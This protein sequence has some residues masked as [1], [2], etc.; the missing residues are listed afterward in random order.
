MS[1]NFNSIFS[2]ISDNPKSSDDVIHSKMTGRADSLKISTSYQDFKEDTTEKEI[3]LRKDEREKRFKDRR[4]QQQIK[5]EV[6]QSLK[7]KMTVAKDIYEEIN[8]LKVTVEDMKNFIF[9]FKSD[10]L[11]SKYIGIVGLR[12][13]LALRNNFSY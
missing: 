4:L 3:K 6:G 9:Q 10:D 11:K 5:V 2:N 13:V 1:H 12:K 7:D 8:K